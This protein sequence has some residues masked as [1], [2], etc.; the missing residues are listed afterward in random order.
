MKRLLITSLL[1]T[2]LLTA[3][4]AQAQDG[5]TPLYVEQAVIGEL[6]A[7]APTAVYSFEVWD[8]LRM[9]MLFDVIAGDMT[10][11]LVVLD[12][13]QQTVLAESSGA[14]N[15]GVIV[16]FPAQG[17]YYLELSAEGGTSAKYRL[18][19]NLSPRLPINPFVSQAFL[20]TGTS[21]ICAENTPVARFAPTQDL[22]VCFVL[23]LLEGPTELKVEWWSPTGEVANEESGTIDTG[24][25]G[26]MLLSGLVYPGTPFE[27]G[28]WQVHILLD[29][30]LTH[31][32]WVAVSSQ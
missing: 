22:N 31:S 16:T 13:D 28:W 5:I 10:P 32:Q 21:S 3:L 4:P 20:V 27:E 2:L 26:Q 24:L 7:D 15:N 25:N 11:N 17:T 1:L 30:E 12:S 14:N 23:E 29:G 9:A 18:M 6:T 19:I 8:S